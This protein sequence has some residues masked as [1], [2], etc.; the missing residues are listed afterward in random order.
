MEEERHCKICGEEL[1]K[2]EQDICNNCQANIITN[3]DTN[4]F[5]F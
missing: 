3:K 5:S 4:L 1:R 2:D